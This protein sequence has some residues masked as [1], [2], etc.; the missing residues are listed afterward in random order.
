MQR[1][2]LGL[3]LAVLS[4]ITIACSGAV[5]APP[6]GSP[7][8]SPSTPPSSPGSPADGGSVVIVAKDLVFQ[9]ETLVVPA[10]TPVEILFDNQDEAPH[11]IA[12]KGGDGVTGFK[13][14]IIGKGQVKNQV[15]AMAPGTYTFWCEVHP[16]M[17]GTIT[18]E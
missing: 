17:T 16:D 12:I 4:A 2:F 13:G 3:G 7:G 8:G 18:A 6:S 14:E 1:F 11:N 15:P 10:G 5:A 9:P